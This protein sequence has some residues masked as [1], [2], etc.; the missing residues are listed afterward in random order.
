MVISQ[1]NPMMATR[2]RDSGDPLLTDQTKK[3]IAKL[4]T[5]P[6]DREHF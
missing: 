1:L 5:E 4:A 6:Y 3:S 2:L